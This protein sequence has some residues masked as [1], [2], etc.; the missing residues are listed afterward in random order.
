MKATVLY[1]DRCAA[2]GR[3]NVLATLIIWL[4]T[5]LGGRTLRLD[6]CSE[7]Y[8]TIA[9]APSPNG[10]APPGP[11]PERV[12]PRRGGR[13]LLQADYTRVLEFART[14]E[15]FARDDL[16]AFLGKATTSAHTTRALA[17]LVEDRKLERYMQGIYQRP[18]Y[19]LAAP[20][21][22]DLGAAAV[23]KLVQARPG[24]RMQVAAAL[25][26]IDSTGLWRAV[27]MTLREQKAVRSKG[28]KSAMRLYPR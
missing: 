19:T 1:C 25:C 10:A 3:G 27:L 28:Q 7:H 18:G 23:L 11:A 6:V 20:A 13:G 8:A 24:V 2:E 16:C 17:L 22:V 26:G 5:S 15:R 12:W 9:G 4:R 21:S 14:H